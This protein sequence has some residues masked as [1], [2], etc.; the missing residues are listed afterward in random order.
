M[1]YIASILASIRGGI[2]RDAFETYFLESLSRLAR[3]PV[4][5][6]RISVARAVAEACQPGE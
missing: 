6:V 5:S 1:T 2:S 3:D 4:V